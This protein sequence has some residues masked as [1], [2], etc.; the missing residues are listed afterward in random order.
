VVAAGSGHR[1]GGM[2][3]FHDLGGRSVAA[4]SVAAARAAT[5]GTVLVVPETGELANVGPEE[6][7]AAGADVVVTGGATRAASVRAG[8][9]AVPDGAAVV[10]VHDAVRPLASP[11]LFAA[12]IDTVRSGKAAGAVPTL[13]VS[14]TIKRVDGLLVH[15]T[16]DRDGLVTVQT[17]QAF[18]ADTLRRA[19]RDDGEATDDAGLLE[20]LGATVCTVAG[21]PRNLKITRPED[22]ELA[23]ALLALRPEMPR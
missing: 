12:V 6:G 2:K 8:L 7:P 20:R 19:H 5:D 11:S 14:D 23:A 9:D 4:W 22:L 18:D 16:V 21:D 3:Q 13:P 1:F 10:V 15:S 17:P